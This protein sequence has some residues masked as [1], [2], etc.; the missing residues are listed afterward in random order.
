MCL[1]N[2]RRRDMWKLLLFH[3]EMNSTSFGE[4][5]FLEESYT[6]DK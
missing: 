2:S 3:T 1:I 5:C 6:H 4:M